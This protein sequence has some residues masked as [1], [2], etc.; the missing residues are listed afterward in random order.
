MPNNGLVYFSGSIHGDRSALEVMKHCVKT[1]KQLGFT[2][3]T[4]Y[5]A[6]NDPR[7]ALAEK[8]KIRP[9]AI[10]NVD[11]ERYDLAW[12]KQASFVIAEVSYP[13]TGVGREIEYGRVKGET[14]LPPARV[15]CLYNAAQTVTPMILGMTPDR[16]PNVMVRSYDS[17]AEAEKIVQEFL[18]AS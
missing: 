14:G 7:V 15:L 5:V 13:S 1:I 12:L 6:A 4:E 3:L 10:T 18:L 11:I 16:Y 9:E 2:V 17:L 8:L